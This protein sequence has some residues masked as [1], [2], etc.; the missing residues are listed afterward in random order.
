MCS[1]V[2]ESQTSALA[3]L[4][5]LLTCL[6]CSLPL[7]APSLLAAEKGNDADIIEVI[8]TIIRDNLQPAKHTHSGSA[9]GTETV[10]LL[11][12]LCWNVKDDL[13]DR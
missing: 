4:L 12:G 9:L 13:M 8:C 2:N 1:F 3:A 10:G 5:N 11:E 6:S 7:F